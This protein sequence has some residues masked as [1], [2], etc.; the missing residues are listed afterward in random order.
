[1]TTITL[2]AFTLVG[3]ANLVHFTPALKTERDRTPILA[4][5]QVTLQSTPGGDG[6]STDTITLT[7]TAT[8]RYMVGHYSVQIP[9]ATVGIETAELA[10]TGVSVLLPIDLLKELKPKTSDDADW[11]ITFT[12]ERASTAQYAPG[13]VTVSN[14]TRS[15]SAVVIGGNYPPVARLLPGVDGSRTDVADLSPQYRLSAPFT[16][17]LAKVVAPGSSR[18]EK[19]DAGWT[20]QGTAARDYTTSKSQPVLW[21]RSFGERGDV[22]VLQQPL[23]PLR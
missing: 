14:G 2:P 1:M 16:A 6:S 12:P 10:D 17:R 15:L 8:D 18:Y 9:A 22:V 5:V 20:L 19:D 3:I 23:L 13:M 11:I 4:T 7:A 21:S